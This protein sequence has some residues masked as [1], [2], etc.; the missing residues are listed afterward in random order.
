MHME[1]RKLCAAEINRQLFSHF[2]RRQTVTKCWRREDGKWVIKE[3][4]FIDDWGETEYQELVRCLINTVNTDGAVFGAF[5]GGA[6]K[7]FAS[8][9]SAPMGQNGE[10]LDLSCIHVSQDLRGR[11]I[12]RTLFDMACRWAREHGAGKLYISAHSAVESQAFYE[13]MGCSEAQEYNRRH[14]EAEPFDC[15]LECVLKD[16]PAKDWGGE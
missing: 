10:Y 1:Y 5:E 7:G 12:G 3:A 4:P 14:V 8:V 16:S 13:A 11:G 6:L 15:Q 2:I 9:E